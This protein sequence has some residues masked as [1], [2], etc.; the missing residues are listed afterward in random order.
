MHQCSTRRSPRLRVS[1]LTSLVFV[2]ALSLFGQDPVPANQFPGMKWRLLG[3]FRGGRVTAV[4]GVPGDPTTYYFGTPGGGI[5]KSTN[6]GRVWFPISDSVRV[7]SIGALAVAPSAANVIYAGTGEQTRGRGVYRSSDSGK[8]WS[9][10]GLEDV[11]Y[12]Q[13]IIVDPQNPEVAVAGGNSIGFGI[14][15]HPTPKSAS[16]DNRGIFRTEDGGKSWKKVYTDDATFGV[17][18]MCCRPQQSTNPLRRD[19]SPGFRQRRKRDSRHFRHRKVYRR[20][21]KLGADDDERLARQGSR[22]NGSCRSFGH[23]GAAAVRDCR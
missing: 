6:G 20:G 15:W 12:I 19:V 17:V 22:T 9:S 14:L 23:A 11:P 21:R 8:T 16:V 1:F 4:A 10:A 5:W 2:L 18:D 3:P 13:A 7:P